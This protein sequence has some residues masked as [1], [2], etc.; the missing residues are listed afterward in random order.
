M[1]DFEIS[2][3]SKEMMSLPRKI[4]ASSRLRL[5]I[6]SFLKSLHR[7]C[8]EGASHT[9]DPHLPSHH[10]DCPFLA[11]DS[12]FN[13]YLNINASLLDSFPLNDRGP[14]RLPCSPLPECWRAI[15]ASKY[16]GGGMMDAVVCPRLGN[17]DSSPPF[18]SLS[19]PYP[20]FS[21]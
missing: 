13:P 21:L 5:I 7:L 18:S 15:A 20:A 12:P 8:T 2:R 10:P 6:S 11:R 4:T 17:S 1:R 9:S 16:D 14:G 3:A 19:S